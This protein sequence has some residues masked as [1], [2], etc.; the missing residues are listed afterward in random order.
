MCLNEAKRRLLVVYISGNTVSS[1]QRGYEQRNA[2][3]GKRWHVAEL[4]LSRG[5]S[6]VRVNEHKLQPIRVSSSASGKQE[7]KSGFQNKA[8]WKLA[9]PYWLFFP[10]QTL[11]IC[12]SVRK[13]RPWRAMNVLDFLDPSVYKLQSTLKLKINKIIEIYKMC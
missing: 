1:R 3:R 8:I 13:L 5:E 7:R 6:P 11:N 12:I 4:F 10:F 9:P 2:M